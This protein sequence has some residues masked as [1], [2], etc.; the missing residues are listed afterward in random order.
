MKFLST[1]AV[2]VL[3]SF[4]APSQAQAQKPTGY[5]PAADPVAALEQA[6]RTARSSGKRVML[7]AGGDWCPW[8]LAL[9]KFIAMD[10]EV[11]AAIDRS[12]VTLKAYYGKENRNAAFFSKLPPAKG[13][14]HIWIIDGDGKVLHSVDTSRLESG[15][16]KYDKAKVL[17][18]VAEMSKG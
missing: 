11:Q 5:D 13:Y 1:L 4:V 10:A 16:Y 18:F 15:E 9:E 3:L 14:P 6:T 8:C 17:Q 12:F 2:F 7:F